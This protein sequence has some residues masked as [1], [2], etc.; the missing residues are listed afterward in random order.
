MG[1][2]DAVLEQWCCTA[3][4]VGGNGAGHPEKLGDRVSF[5]GNLCMLWLRRKARGIPKLR[6]PGHVALRCW[7]S[8]APSKPSSDSL[9]TCHQPRWP[10]GVNVTNE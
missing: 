10:Q 1:Q 6:C 7:S 4:R 8:N 3:G 2:E 9:S 5:Q